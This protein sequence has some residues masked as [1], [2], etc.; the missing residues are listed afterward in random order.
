MTKLI[1]QIVFGLSLLVM[2]ATASAVAIYPNRIIVEGKAGTMASVQLKVY[3]HTETVDVDFVK[4]ADLTSL[5][6]TVL[7]T[8]VL[9]RESQIIIP[10]DIKIDKTKDYYLCAVLKKS[11]SMRLRV[12][13]AVRVIVNQ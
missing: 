2:A 5:D 8:F 12:C 6:D 1:S 3:G 4:V 9:A 13:S 7:S 11:Q 10:V